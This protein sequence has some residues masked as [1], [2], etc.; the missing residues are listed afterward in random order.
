[1]LG[2]IV[3]ENKKNQFI[4]YLKM[5]S[6]GE[7][8]KPSETLYCSCGTDCRLRCRTGGEERK[9]QKGNQT[10]GQVAPIESG[11]GSPAT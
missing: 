11:R 3:W 5:G 7:V 8:E 2:R 10:V 1:M 9:R 6:L 4:K